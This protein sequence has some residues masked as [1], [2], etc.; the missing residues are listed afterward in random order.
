MYLI[1][2]KKNMLTIK[3]D[4]ALVNT[5]L[6]TTRN[7]EERFPRRMANLKELTELF[8]A[9][10]TDKS[11]ADVSKAMEALHQFTLE[12]LE[13][14]P[15][16]DYAARKAALELLPSYEEILSHVRTGKT[17]KRAVKDLMRQVWTE[18]QPTTQPAPL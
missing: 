16:D 1:A 7:P 9:S 13:V 5:G 12:Y 4:S 15:T 14:V 11:F 2:R 8:T 17:V 3:H 6:I 18:F 10:L